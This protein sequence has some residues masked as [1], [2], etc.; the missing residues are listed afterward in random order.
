MSLFFYAFSH[1]IGQNEVQFPKSWVG[2]WTGQLNIYNR[3]GLARQIHMEV[4]IQPTLKDDTWKWTLIYEMDT[5]RDER[6]YE[7]IVVDEEKGHYQIDEKNSI[8]LDSFLF[9]NTLSSR[10]AVSKSLLMVNYTLE[11]EK[12]RF[13]I[14]A[15]R[16]DNTVETG[17][18]VEDAGGIFSYMLQGM[19]RAVLSRNDDD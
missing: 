7:L 2:E 14:F 15:G 11:D 6:K 16:T 1:G 18:E 9:H 5:I 13:E 4:H 3:D 19:H 17:E 12:L 10:F 8:F